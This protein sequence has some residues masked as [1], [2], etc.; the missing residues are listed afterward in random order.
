MHCVPTEA[1]IVRKFN[2]SLI[3]ILPAS[4]LSSEEFR[5]ALEGGHFW[6]DDEPDAVDGE[7]MEIDTES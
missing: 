6:F 5:E 1:Y 2:G 7:D 3:E 4:E